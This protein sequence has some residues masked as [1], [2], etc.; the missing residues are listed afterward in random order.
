MTPREEPMA[1][2]I[3]KKAASMV[4]E[5]GEYSTAQIMTMLTI[6]G[7]EAAARAYADAAKIVRSIHLC[8]CSPSYKDRLMTSPSCQRCEDEFIALEF[9]GKASALRSES[10]TTKDA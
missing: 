1:E 7:R 8:D 3:E 4:V 6:F 10:R 5:Y 9:D 2:W